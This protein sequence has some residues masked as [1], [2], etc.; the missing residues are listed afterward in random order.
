MFAPSE[1]NQQRR[2]HHMAN[3][4]HGRKWFQFEL[5][6]N[7]D[8]LIHD[9]FNRVASGLKFTGPNR[10]LVGEETRPS[11]NGGFVVQFDGVADVA[12]VQ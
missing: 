6:L 4:L 3:R 5:L 9:G 10:G 1:E 12:F 11:V 2:E 7:H 8:A